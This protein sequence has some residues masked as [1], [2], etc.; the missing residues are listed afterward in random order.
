MEID[1][2]KK[3]NYITMLVNLHNIGSICSVL[4]DFMNCFAAKFP[5]I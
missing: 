4:A 3:T 2:I 1:D 5:G